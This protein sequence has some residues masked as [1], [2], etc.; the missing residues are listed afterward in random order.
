LSLVL[1]GHDIMANLRWKT[2][3]AEDLCDS[4]P[5]NSLAVGDGGL[6]SDLAGIEL[7]TPLDC[8]AECLDDA[9][10]ANP[11]GRAGRACPA[12]GRRNR[13]DDLARGYPARQT[14]NVAAPERRVRPQGDFDS[15]FAVRGRR[16]AVGGRKTVVEG[17][18]DDP[19]NDQRFLPDRAEPATPYFG[20]ARA[21]ALSGFTGRPQIDLPSP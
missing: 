1:S 2:K 19:E 3:Q 14:A 5:T 18:M 6:V 16:Q 9:W 7:A 4:R 20:L 10:R 8:L 17:D 12:A 21:P 13:V 11:L 15:L